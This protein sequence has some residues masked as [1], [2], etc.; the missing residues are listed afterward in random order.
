[1]PTEAQEETETSVNQ[2][3]VF[4]ASHWGKV[5]ALVSAIA[6][7]IMAAWTFERRMERMECSIA[8]HELAI[9]N[10][11]ARD[12]ALQLSDLEKRRD[13]AAKRGDDVDFKAMVSAIGSNLF[14][15]VNL[16]ARQAAANKRREDC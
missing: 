9:L 2:V 11:E 10:P 16:T 4:V 14:A 12:L 5:T 1:M 6:A 15:K 8:L 3:L 7:V 13:D